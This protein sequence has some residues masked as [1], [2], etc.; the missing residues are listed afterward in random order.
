MKNDNKNNSL[1]KNKKEKHENKHK[2][3]RDIDAMFEDTCCNH[4]KIAILMKEVPSL[5]NYYGRLQVVPIVA[6]KIR[7]KSLIS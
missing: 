5:I 2:T 7:L 3:L 1:D 6:K 4:Q